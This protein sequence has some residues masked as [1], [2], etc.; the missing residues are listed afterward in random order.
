MSTF[1][2]QLLQNIKIL[3]I[4]LLMLYSANCETDADDSSNFKPTREEIE[5]LDSKN[6]TL[7]ER[8]E[9]LKTQDFSE[10]IVDIEIY[11]KAVEYILEFPEQIYNRKYYNDA[12]YLLEAGL[13]RIADLERGG[14]KWRTENG[15]VC[16]GYM[17]E[18][19]GS[20]QPFCIWVPE[21]YNPQQ[22]MRLDVILHGRNRKLNEVSFL[23]SGIDGSIISSETGRK[24]EPDCLKLYVFGRGNNSYRW[25]GE[26]DV[27]E[28]LKSVQKRYNVD[29]ERIVLRGFSMGGTGA[30]HLGLH[31]P[32]KW[33]A[34]EAGAG[35]VQTRP[36]VLQTIT[37][38]WRFD[39]LAIHDAANCAINMINLPFVAYVGANDRQKPQIDIIRSNL[40]NEGYEPDSL[41]TVKFLTGAETGHNF[42]PEMKLVS[43][44]F[45]KK[46]LPQGPT[47]SDFRFV[48]YTPSYG[49][50]WGFEIDSLETLYQRAEIRGNSENLQTTNIWVL[51]L[52]EARQLTIDGQKVS[53]ASFHKDKG[54]WREGTPTGLRKKAGLQGPIDDAFQQPFFCVSPETGFDPILEKFEED[55][56][57]YMHGEIRR[58]LPSEVTSKDLEQYNLILFGDPSSNPWI[59]KV[60]PG[61]PLKWNESEIRIAGRIYS[62][63]ENIVKLIYP[64]PLYPQRYVVLNSGHTFPGKDFDDMHWYLHP[65]FGDYA[66]I[67]KR[68]GKVRLAGFF[69]KRWQLESYNRK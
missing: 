4:L 63:Q 42:R 23:A 26:S 25:A 36:E 53:G 68:T 49:K 22:P 5:V 11:H 59:E 54:V 46:S 3:F 39:S 40:K 2:D 8:I 37:E 41:P 69:N 64:N 24:T 52:N 17:S 65:R 56:F 50:F 47:P 57:Q 20:I 67:D 9:K 7:A 62:S 10:L 21:D 32:S 29:S 30:W 38:S 28:A 45:I 14:T 34:V 19:D 44:G 55:F 12:L 31:F 1:T 61:L 16:Q 6:Q 66:I 48:C 58:K 60:L 43:D 51:K 33:A 35:F 18:V 15:I 13:R 27:F